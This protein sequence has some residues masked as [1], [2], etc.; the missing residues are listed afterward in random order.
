MITHRFELCLGWQSQFRSFG[1]ATKQG[2]ELICLM[3][4]QRPALTPRTTAASRP[5]QG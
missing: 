3:P 2:N 1:R 5:L 4:W